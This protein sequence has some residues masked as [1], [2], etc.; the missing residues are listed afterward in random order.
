MPIF[1]SGEP[2][3][4]KC[5]DGA[6][7]RS[8]VVVHLRAAGHAKAAR[9]LFVERRQIW[10]TETTRRLVIDTRAAGHAKAARRLVILG[11]LG[12][13][14]SDRLV[15][16]DR[17]T[18]SAAGARQ[19]NAARSNQTH[20][21]GRGHHKTHAHRRLSLPRANA[22]AELKAPAIAGTALA[23]VLVDVAAN[24]PGGGSV[25]AAKACLRAPGVGRARNPARAARAALPLGKSDGHE[26]KKDELHLKGDKKKIRPTQKPSSS[27]PNDV[28]SIRKAVHKL[29]SKQARRRRPSNGSFPKSTWPTPSIASDVPRADQRHSRLTLKLFLCVF[30]RFFFLVA[31]HPCHNSV[32]DKNNSFL[33]RQFF[34]RTQLHSVKQ[35]PHALQI[36]VQTNQGTD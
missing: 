23:L 33:W 6:A 14:H 18:T 26:Q 36:F 3:E 22:L 17:R 1:L 7:A 8:S 35:L 28:A 20:A 30:L 13:A 11:K 15:V 31:D 27:P 25:G 12:Q 16:L 4:T 34:P 24:R 5:L 19:A 9:R 10:H 2:G 29:C 32:K 21:N